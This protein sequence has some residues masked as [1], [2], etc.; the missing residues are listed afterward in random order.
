[1]ESKNRTSAPSGWSENAWFR[2]GII[3]LLIWIT[4][5]FLSLNTE[6]DRLVE[7]IDFSEMLQAI[8][9][10]HVGR[11]SVTP[12]D[13]ITGTWTQDRPGGKKQ[14][15]VAFPVDNVDLV[16][17][18]AEK[19]GIPVAFREPA[20]KL[21]DTIGVVLQILLLSLLVYFLWRSTRG[22]DHAKIGGSG[23]LSTTTF[24]DVA[25]TEGADDELREMV[26]FLRNPDSFTSLG[27]RLP[28]G[29]LLVGPPGTGKTLLARAIAGEANVPVH[30]VSGSEFTGPFVGIGVMRLKNFFRDARKRGGVIF[31]DE[32]D[33]L[34]G[35]RG[36][37]QVHNEDERT[38]THL[39][40]ELD[41]FEQGQGILVLG[42]TNRPEALDPALLRPGRFD[43]IITV[44]L[45]NVEGRHAI[46]KLHA[47]RR[48]MSEDVDLLRLA[49]LTPGSS[50]AEL[51][52]L[53]NEAA[54]AA[55]REKASKIEWKHI[56]IARDRIML[57]RERVGFKAK[58]QELRLVAY[59]EAGHALA[60]V[61]ACPQDGLHKVTIQ[62][63]G[64]AMGVA[65]FSPED[66]RHLYSRA[67][68]EGQIIKGLA[69]RV[70][71]QIVFGPESITSGAESDLIQVNRIARK[72]I[73]R[74]GMGSSGLLVMDEEDA[75]LSPETL[76]A[77][78]GEIG[79]LLDLM[80]E[81]AT[82][83][84]TTHRSAL[85]ALAQALLERETLDGAEA[86]RILRE[87]DVQVEIL[88]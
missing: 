21:G 48:V 71:E 22:P 29:A 19:A 39:L 56:E 61:V 70:A 69:G 37:N 85:D 1:M 77:M 12:G 38:L 24:S 65:H 33:V 41:G 7:D 76:N 54:L 4:A 66:D 62:P 88:A 81:K 20:N 83:I 16:V 32:I 17:E 35:R 10:S 40:S 73:C 51:E 2:W 68:L 74:L 86:L 3:L 26:D 34:G 15:Q 53:I 49:R 31:I 58:E 55:G 75:R 84:L 25:G 44:G 6:R 64:R 79:D 50:G 43:R 78:D 36:R 30:V 67:Y 11:I 46:L 60:G 87:H 23:E 80:Y 18:R 63:R 5:S 59:H 52:N 9:S 28:K 13:R 14:F 57:G 42:A 82:R 72:M 27:A 47:S 8:D 45:P